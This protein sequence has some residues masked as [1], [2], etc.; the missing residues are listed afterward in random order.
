MYAAPDVF[1][2]EAER[3]HSGE[4]PVR[5]GRCLSILRLRHWLIALSN[6]ILHSQSTF[7]ACRD[8]QQSSQPGNHCEIYIE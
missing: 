2:V 1:Q 7:F 4:V 6:M 5:R 3:N 8:F